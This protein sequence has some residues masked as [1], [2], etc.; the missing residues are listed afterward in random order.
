LRLSIVI[1]SWNGPASLERCLRSLE[2]QAAGSEIIAVTNFDRGA[3]EMIARAFPDVRHVSMPAGTTVPVLRAEGIRQSSGEIVA[4]AE[5]HCT[6]AANW[7][8][9]LVKAQ[10]LPY[11][12]VGGAVENG[13]PQSALAWAVYF[14]D[15]GKFMLPLTAGPAS[16]LSGNNVSYKRAALLEVEPTFR[17][18]L[19]EP[20]T[21]G[22]LA[23]RGYPLY[24]TPGV[25][26]YHQKEYRAGD[27][28]AQAYHLA[29]DFAA[30][31]V[32][33]APLAKRAAFVAGSVALPIVLP[34]RILLRTLRKRRF[35][36]ELLR[37]LPYL[38]LLT[39]SWSLGEFLGYL[40]GAGSS[41]GKW[42]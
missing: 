39:G 21:H 22:E 32:S 34:G 18:G 17:E 20:F 10:E 13:S 41:T 38:V 40:A 14:Y 42:K 2:G 29:R 35:L 12:A 15:Y 5:D 37:C 19:F 9:E 26:V 28:I 11:S 1:A 36:P 24:L 6:F 33:G 7:C 23:R 3:E 27:A 31:R 25:I 4:L 16:A 8:A 30:K